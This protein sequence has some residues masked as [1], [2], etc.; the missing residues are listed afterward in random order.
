MPV[1]CSRPARLGWPAGCVR[2]SSDRDWKQ[3]LRQNAP[4]ALLAFRSLRAPDDMLQIYPPYF[5][6]MTAPNIMCNPP[7][8]AARK[9]FPQCQG[10]KRATAPNTMKQRPIKGTTRI[11]NAPPVTTPVP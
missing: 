8:P 7:K 2:E 3:R 9:R 10:Q 11:E 4:E 1:K 6:A 5:L